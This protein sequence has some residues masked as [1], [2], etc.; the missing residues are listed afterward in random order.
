MRALIDMLETSK[1]HAQ[2]PLIDGFWLAVTDEGYMTSSIVAVDRE[3]NGDPEHRDALM[4]VKASIDK[5]FEN[6]FKASNM[7][8]ISGKTNELIEVEIE[9]DELRKPSDFKHRAN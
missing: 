2:V 7:S 8:E 5:A 1:E 9:T 3:K 6:V 4:G